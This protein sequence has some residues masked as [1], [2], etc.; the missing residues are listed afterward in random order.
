[1][2]WEKV[3]VQKVGNFLSTDYF[4]D[5][6]IK[7]NKEKW[8]N[9]KVRKE[10]KREKEKLHDFGLKRERKF[11]PIRNDFIYLYNLYI[12]NREFLL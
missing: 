4:N 2:R 5:P 6:N 9:K 12:F 10:K 8:K 11:F 1:M 7:F 3:Y